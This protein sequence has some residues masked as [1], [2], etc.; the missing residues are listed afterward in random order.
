[1]THAF[2][3]V[4]NVDPDRKFYR[5]DVFIV[6]GGSS[7]KGFPFQKLSGRNCI[8]VNDAFRLGSSVVSTCVFGDSSWFHRTKWDLE[9][10]TGK[11][12]CVCPSLHGIKAPWMVK[13]GRAKEGM[14]DSQHIP[15]FYSTGAAAIALACVLG[16]QRV[17]LLGFDMVQI[18]N[19]T[20]WHRHHKRN[21]QPEA[22]R[23]HML[24]M[25]ELAK[26][27]KSHTQ[28]HIINLSDVSALECFEKV[29]MSRLS[30]FLP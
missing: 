24:G 18:K 14:G 9:K 27:I 4:L 16:A 3:N 30:E 26:L 13:L 22:F 7:L 10:Y 29:P 2:D 5:S 23:R 6:G 15:W 25:M 11:V 12:V 17:L 1:M 21:T 8:G 20:H 19:A 28:S